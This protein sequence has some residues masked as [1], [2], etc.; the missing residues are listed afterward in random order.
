VL[1]NVGAVAEQYRVGSG[2][3]GIPWSFVI[4]KDG[5]LRATII[6]EATPERLDDA[7][8]KVGITY[9]AN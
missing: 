8:S 5:V 2:G 7:L 6:G 3:K 4:D 9:K 1:D